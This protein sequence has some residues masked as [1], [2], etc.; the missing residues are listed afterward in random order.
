[1]RLHSPLPHSLPPVLSLPCT[2]P[3]CRCT[4]HNCPHKSR[5]P[6]HSGYIPNAAPDSSRHCPANASCLRQLSGKDHVSRSL[7]E[8]RRYNQILSLLRSF[9]M[10]KY[11]IYDNRLLPYLL[12]VPRPAGP[13]LSWNKITEASGMI[14]S[15]PRHAGTALSDIPA[16]DNKGNNKPGYNGHLHRY[17]PPVKHH[18]FPFLCRKAR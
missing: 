9:H 16:A 12:H 13:G 5:W 17:F 10:Q 8:T 1:M 11:L 15:I 14:R 18:I 3:G 4:A 6:A 2:H 7:Q